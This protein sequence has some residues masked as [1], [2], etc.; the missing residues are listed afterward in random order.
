MAPDL[1]K[2]LGR[3]VEEARERLA[4][5]RGGLRALEGGSADRETLDA[6]FRSAHTI[7]GSAKMLGQGGIGETAH[8]LEDL[9]EA[10][11]S[12]KLSADEALLA[13]LRRGTEALAE[14]VER[15]A[16][17]EER[18]A[19]DTAAL[20]AMAGLLAP[21]RL[22]STAEVREPA[23]AD[24]GAE[25]SSARPGH[26]APPPSVAAKTET[27][28]LPPSAAPKTETAPRSGLGGESVRVRLA[29]LDEMLRLS[30]EALAA[31]ARTAARLEELA[32]I[33]RMAFPAGM[34]EAERLRAF[35]ER[36]GRF[37]RELRADFLAREDLETEL[38]GAA[39][40]LR[41]LPLSLVFEPTERMARELGRELGK[42]LD[43]LCEG[44]EIELD[45]ELIDGLGEP[46]LH[47]VRNAIDH[48]IEDPGRRESLG[49]S[50]RGRL[51]IGARQAEGSV[52]VEVEDDGGGLPL[53]A[54]R[55]KA[56]RLR[57]L[58]PERA[59]GLGP[60][61]LAEL[62][63][64]PGLST[65]P[66]VTELS[67]RGVG[68][69]AVRKAVVEG[70]RGGIAVETEAGRGTRF[71]LSLP[72][73]L[74]S[75]RVLF[76]RASGRDFAFA[77]R[78]VAGILSLGE[79]EL[80]TVA[81]GRAAVFRDEFVAVAKLGERLGLPSPA[82]PSPAGTRLRLLVLDE[83][84]ERLA[85]EIDELLDEG[86]AVVKPLPPQLRG[87]G[88]AAGFIERGDGAL[89]CLLNARALLRAS[90]ETRVGAPGPGEAGG[91]EILIVDDSLN[92]R[93]I[94]RDVLE[95]HG[96]RITLAEDGAEGLELALARRFDA[97]LTD[98]EMPRM[99]GFELTARLRA[100]EAYRDAPIVILTSRS[101]EEDRRRGVRAGADAYIVKGD[102]DQGSL[103]ETL[104]GLGL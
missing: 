69:D 51:R 70:L 72:P 92:T 64:L 101:R 40:A 57:L 14:L 73:T 103:L 61:E 39:L 3:F 59:A 44:G 63:F 10:L 47:L 79:E 38:H 85:L 43:C 6:L 18:P 33:E 42:E 34:G 71:S 17:G 1:K 84:S 78:D 83:G 45:R 15:L 23:E 75:M 74:A 49:K 53:E 98:V 28:P 99:D 11:R 81:G 104:R 48:G 52:I 8:S 62:I 77:A 100:E 90:R 87:L 25:G 88:P 60:R 96:Y 24:E 94:E 16:G 29:K 2:F 7:K 67:G 86:E 58:E 68:L 21:A 41:M 19:A 50:R 12:E 26:A 4:G 95:A 80:F 9:L 36:L 32:S 37:R 66:I 30:G 91:A 89:L 5:L 27:A 20:A 56:L 13:G 22:P 31:R 35:R 65:S 93:E 54:I 102:F 46:L 76:V 55:D 97:V 82:R